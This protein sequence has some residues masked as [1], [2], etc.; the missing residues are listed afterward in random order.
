MTVLIAL[1]LFSTALLAFSF[2]TGVAASLSVHGVERATAGWSPEGRHRAWLLLAVAPPLLGMAAALATFAPSFLAFVWPAFDHC[3]VHPGH[4]HLCFVHPPPSLASPLVWGPLVCAVA[5]V[6]IRIG[7][8]AFAFRRASRMA[9][10][11]LARVSNER[12]PAGARL[13]PTSRP[14][15]LTVGL[16]RP[17]MV[18]SKG[19]IGSVSD[20]ELEAMLEHERA[21]ARRRDTLVR[22]LAE[23]ASVFMWSSQR[24]EV[25]R[26]LDLAAEQSSDEAAASSMGDRLTVAEAILKVER[27]VHA[28]PWEL[29]PFAASFG[30][31]GVPERVRALLEP[32]RKR[33]GARLALTLVLGIAVA[34]VAAGDPF[35]HALET[36][37]GAF[38][39]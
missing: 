35:H 18:L 3:L 14:L 13:L 5:F 9:K 8:T 32:R 20:R 27:L 4:V 37:L 11:L 28:S 26:A 33:S 6:A 2:L 25:L 39:S 16:V 34:L 22:L 19:L 36:L 21:H 30:G 38:M 24:V 1:Q 29:R 31:A 17:V 15:C 12:G 23:L 7:T 10:G